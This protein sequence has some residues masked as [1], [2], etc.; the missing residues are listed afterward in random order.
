VQDR[1]NVEKKVQDT[2]QLDYSKSETSTV[3]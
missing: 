2:T 3:Y 1:N